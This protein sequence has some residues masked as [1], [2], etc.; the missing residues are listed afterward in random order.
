MLIEDLDGMALELIEAA[1]S[2]VGVS[3]SRR[4][5]GYVRGRWHTYGSRR[6]A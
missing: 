4:R 1:P 5:Q 3:G 2:K 6:D